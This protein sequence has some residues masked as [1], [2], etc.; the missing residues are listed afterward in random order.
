MAGFEMQGEEREREREEEEEEWKLARE[1]REMG[2]KIEGNHHVGVRDM[3]GKKTWGEKVKEKTG[4]EVEIKKKT[5]VSNDKFKLRKANDEEN[6]IET[7]KIRKNFKKNGGGEIWRIVK[8]IAESE[9]LERKEEWKRSTK[10]K[11]GKRERVW[12][13]WGKRERKFC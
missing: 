5:T 11:G 9:V 13:S 12:E 7:S 1:K 4:K 3:K 8:K 6:W 2:S 10:R